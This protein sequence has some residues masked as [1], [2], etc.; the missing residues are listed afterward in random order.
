[1]AVYAELNAARDE[2]VANP[3]AGGSEEQHF[4]HSIGSSSS[5]PS[6]SEPAVG[7]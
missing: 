2:V 5:A 1:M 6:S 3:G 4:Y 7:V